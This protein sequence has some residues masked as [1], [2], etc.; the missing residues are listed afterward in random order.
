MAYAPSSKHRMIYPQWLGI[1]ERKQGV[2]KDK[3]SLCKIEEEE[4]MLIFDKRTRR[5]AVK[6]DPKIL[7]P[8][9]TV[10][11]GIKNHQSFSTVFCSA[12]QKEPHFQCLPEDYVETSTY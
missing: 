10:N 8:V 6:H 11:P 4:V 9:L 2:S 1:Q 5:V 7:V 12:T 3:L